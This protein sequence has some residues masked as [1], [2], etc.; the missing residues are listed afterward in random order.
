MENK[1]RGT[2]MK[3][4]ILETELKGERDEGRIP[5]REIEICR[6]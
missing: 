4:K 1:I 2:P 5:R 6:Q 3:R